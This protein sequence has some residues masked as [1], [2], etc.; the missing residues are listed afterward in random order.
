LKQI[1]FEGIEK[2]IKDELIR[3]HL[4]K[5]TKVKGEQA[6]EEFTSEHTDSENMFPLLNLPARLESKT[7]VH[8]EQAPL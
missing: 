4:L 2:E 6:E 1:D 3:R 7:R 5:R 8:G